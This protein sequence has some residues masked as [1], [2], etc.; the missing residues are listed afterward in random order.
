MVVDFIDMIE[1]RHQQIVWQSLANAIKGDRGQP[2]LGYFSEFSLLE[3]TRHRQ[4]KSLNE[5]LTSKCPYCDGVGRIRNSV[6]RNDLLS[7]DSIQKR[8]PNPEAIRNEFRGEDTLKKSESFGVVDYVENKVVEIPQHIEK[9]RKNTDSNQIE[10]PKYD[11]NNNKYDDLGNDDKATSDVEV[12][13]VYDLPV[14]IE[15]VE[16]Y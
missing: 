1:S 10:Y 7:N 4:K 15:T 16:S 12:V 6:Y 5:L 9:Q 13:E 8:I 11:R 14:S 2:Q 3:M